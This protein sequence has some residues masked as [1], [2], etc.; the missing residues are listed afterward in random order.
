MDSTLNRKQRDRA[1]LTLLIICGLYNTYEQWCR[2]LLPFTQ[3]QLLP[4]P[5]MFDTLLLNAIGTVAILIGS[6]F[7]AQIIDSVGGRTAAVFATVFVGIYQAII[8]WMKSYYVFGGMQ[9]LLFFNHMPTIIDALIGQLVGENA[10]NKE[11]TKV[12][13]R[14]IIPTSIAFATG[15]YLAVQI[16]Y[17]FNPGLEVVQMLC[18]IL[19]ILTV[20]P[21][22]I[23]FLPEEN[24][25]KSRRIELPNVSSFVNILKDRKMIWSLVFVMLVMGPYSAY[26][27]V[28]RTHLTGTM[29]TK[30]NEMAKMALLLG[31]TAFIANIFLLPYLQHKMRPSKLIQLSLTL[32]TGAYMYLSQ[33]TEYHL[34]LI[35]MPFQVIGVCIALGQLSAHIMSSVPRSH[36]GKAAAL[37]RIAQLTATAIVPLVTGYYTDNEEAT[38]LCYISA[39]ISALTIPLIHRYGDFVGQCPINNLPTRYE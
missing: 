14:T 10:D 6:V 25:K 8:C 12:L 27:Q 39:A 7:V 2:I 37:N 33:V 38:T 36:M 19:H 11:R 29:L 5:S 20:L 24:N 13:M 1:K 23:I 34:V 21:I 28:M 9:L 30:P 35:G 16:L 22:I 26:D 4:R 3:W 32:T 18:G 31:S 17:L 15:P